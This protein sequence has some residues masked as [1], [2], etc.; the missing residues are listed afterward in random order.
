MV[1][2]LNKCI[3]CQTCTAACKSSWTDEP[4]QEYMLWKKVETN[5]VRDIRVAGDRAAADGSTANC[6]ACHGVHARGVDG[7]GISLV[8]SEFAGSATPEDL[9]EFRRAGRRPNDPASIMGRPMPA[10][11][12]IAEED[13]AAV[14]GDLVTLHR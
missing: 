14:A 4:G 7:L 11:N 13:L 2:D 6:I 3:G 9:T 1:M 10:F 12:S 5:R 8:D